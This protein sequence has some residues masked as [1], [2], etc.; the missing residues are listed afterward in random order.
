MV[1]GAGGKSNDREVT[2]GGVSCPA[3][4]C[5]RG[6]AVPR[7]VGDTTGCCVERSHLVLVLFVGFFCLFRVFKKSFFF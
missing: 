3:P 4:P 1:P 5:P 2:Q 7:A 6:E